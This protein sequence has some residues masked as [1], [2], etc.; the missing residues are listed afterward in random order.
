MAA[1]LAAA[2]V[3]LITPVARAAPGRVVSQSLTA[4]PSRVPLVGGKYPATEVWAYNASV[5]GPVRR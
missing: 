5:P 3:P 1:G 2:T 4:G